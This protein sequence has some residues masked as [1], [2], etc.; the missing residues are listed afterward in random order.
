MGD[1]ILGKVGVD[2]G[3]NMPSAMRLGRGLIAFN[4]D[5]QQLKVDFEESI[6][7]ILSHT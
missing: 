7:V 3:E 1:D 5:H 6:N 2:L 4:L